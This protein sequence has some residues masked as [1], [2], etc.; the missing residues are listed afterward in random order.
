MD[1]ERVLIVLLN[2]LLMVVLIVLR[3]TAGMFCMKV[4]FGDRYSF[5]IA[6]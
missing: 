6:L 5:N 3:Y 1:V 4:S 2:V